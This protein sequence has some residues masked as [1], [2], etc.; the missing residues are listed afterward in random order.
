MRSGLL[1]LSSALLTGC[2]SFDILHKDYGEQDN[3]EGYVFYAP[4]ALYS[5][6]C[7]I[8]EKGA[9]TYTDDIKYVPDYSR[10]Y[11]LKIKNRLGDNNV[12]ADFNN[13]WMLSSINGEYKSP[14]TT[15]G[16]VLDIGDKALGAF[17]ASQQQAGDGKITA[18]T[19]CESYICDLKE[20]QDIT[21]INSSNCKFFTNTKVI[22]VT[23]SGARR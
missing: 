9:I 1:L 7:N 16:K 19:S 21:K 23:V 4:K 22:E 13:G 17:S 14:E 18:T 20:V 11:T 5:H 15:F 6:S 8:N 2:S 3:N 10:P 12:K